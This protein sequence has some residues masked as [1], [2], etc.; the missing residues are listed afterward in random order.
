MTAPEISS[1][2]WSMKVLTKASAFGVLFGADYESLLASL[3]RLCASKPPV[4][5]YSQFS[6]RLQLPRESARDDVRKLR[7]PILAAIPDQHSTLVY[8]SGGSNFPQHSAL[9]RLVPNFPPP[10]SLWESYSDKV[11]AAQVISI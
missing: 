7:P 9:I 4:H 2:N 11:R 6:F 8:D 10:T 5:V 3:R 1:A